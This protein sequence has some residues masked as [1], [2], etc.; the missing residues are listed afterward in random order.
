MFSGDRVSVL[1]TDGQTVT[2]QGEHQ[3]CPGKRSC[4]LRGGDEMRR[5]GV[6][7]HRSLRESP[8]RTSV[9]PGDFSRIS[10]TLHSS[11]GVYSQVT[12]SV[13]MI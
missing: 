9:L 13:K 3:A 6:T 11:T 1:E 8:Q 2:Q 12:V 10:S 4:W 5:A 7:V